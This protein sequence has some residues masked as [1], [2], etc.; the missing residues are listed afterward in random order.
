MARHAVAVLLII[1]A[2]SAC[3]P[4]VT[5][6]LPSA[7]ATLAA[8]AAPTPSAAVSTAP[9][10]FA[11]IC[12]TT[13]GFVDAF[14]GIVLDAPGREPLKITIPTGRIG[15]GGYV[16]VGVFAGVP[17]PLLDGFFPQGTPGFV[18]R[19]VVPATAAFPAPTGFVL[20]AACA[21]VAPPVVSADQIDWK[22]DCGA[23]NNNNARGTFGTALAQQGW[24]SCAAGLATAQWRKNGVMLAAVE[25]SLAPGDYPRLTQFARLIAPCL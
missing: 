13:G 18:E 1:V 7:S 14:S 25:S 3:T 12:G 20:P 15:V 8:T 17:Y 6:P 2:A 5:A 10:T 9:R 16:C 11:S 19:G 24:I 23:A 21:F 22:I 4:S